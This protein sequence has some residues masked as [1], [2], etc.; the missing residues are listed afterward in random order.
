MGK[1][2]W[3]TIAVSKRT[4]AALER[5]RESMIAG[6]GN[7]VLPLDSRQC[8]SGQEDKRGRIGL[9]R[10]VRRLIADRLRWQRR[11]AKGKGG[12]GLP[13]NDDQAGEITDHTGP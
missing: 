2:M 7:A 8:R 4:L 12:N 9:D 6:D 5:V 1:G 3:T 11:R 10:V 13:A